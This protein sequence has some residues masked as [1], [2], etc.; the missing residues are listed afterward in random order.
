MPGTRKRGKLVDISGSCEIPTAWDAKY[1]GHE[2]ESSSSNP[3]EA[4]DQVSR[5]IRLNPRV[6]VISIKFLQWSGG[7]IHQDNPTARPGW[8]AGIH[9]GC[10]SQ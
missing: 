2:A 4:D 9:L 7:L 1:A 10:S 3:H 8:F 5:T 6:V